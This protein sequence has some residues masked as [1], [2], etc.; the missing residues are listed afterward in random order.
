MWRQGMQ[1]YRILVGAGG[2]HVGTTSHSI[3]EQWDCQA[4]DRWFCNQGSNPTQ[5]MFIK[6][7]PPTC[8]WIL[9][10]TFPLLLL[11]ALLNSFALWHS[12]PL[13]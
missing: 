6:D 12:W 1:E 7:N 9:I 2:S 10:P 8:I 11:K 4:I 13:H 5:K 3:F